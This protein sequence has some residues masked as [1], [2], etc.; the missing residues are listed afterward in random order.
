MLDQL[1]PRPP[2]LVGSCSTCEARCGAFGIPSSHHS[3][4]PAQRGRC[5][6]PSRAVQGLFAPPQYDGRLAGGATRARVKM[7]SVR[8]SLYA[9]SAA[10]STGTRSWRPG[11]WSA[12]G[13]DRPRSAIG[14]SAPRGKLPAMF[15][16]R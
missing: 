8:F 10:A 16:N 7:V 12:R 3:P 2:L 11:S 9:M 1:M 13:P 15:K 14:I 5:P 4:Y 6:V